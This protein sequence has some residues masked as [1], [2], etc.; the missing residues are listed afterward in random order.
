MTIES[1]HLGEYG[2]VIVHD[3]NEVTYLG[4][5]DAL[6]IALWV[7]QQRD[8]LVKRIPKTQGETSNEAST[9]LPDIPNA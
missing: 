7:L 4:A 3:K 5:Q 2:I 9:A 8:E 1:I 6:D